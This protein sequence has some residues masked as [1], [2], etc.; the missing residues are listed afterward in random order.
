MKK[1]TAVAALIL[2]CGAIGYTHFALPAQIEASFNKR[3]AYDPGEISERARALHETLFVADLHTDSLLWKRD[4]T[5]RSDVG[6]VDVPRMHDGNVAL[7]VFSATTKSPEGQNVS[8]NTGDSDNITKLAVAS[9][10]PPR[11]WDSIYERAVYQLD[12][13]RNLAEESD[14]QVVTTKREMQE[15][16][17]RRANG[18]KVIGGIYLIEGAHPLE[19]D[20]ENLDRLYEQ[21]AG[22]GLRTSLIMN[23]ADRCT[24]SAKMG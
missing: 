17:D 3:I 7:Q 9:M 13:L 6:H 19:G 10:W 24:V 23:S 12:K 18:E 16:V 14:V 22:M 21:P 1:K 4:L 8:S 2:V 15:I 5:K 11:T 20:I